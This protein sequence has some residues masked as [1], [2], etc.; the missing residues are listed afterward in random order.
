MLDNL[1]ETCRPPSCWPISHAQEHAYPHR[2]PA[3]QCRSATSPS[4]FSFDSRWPLLAGFGALMAVT[5]AGFPAPRSFTAR[6]NVSDFRTAR[7]RADIE[8]LHQ[9]VAVLNLGNLCGARMGWAA[10]AAG[11]TH[12]LN[13]PAEIGNKEKLPSPRATALLPG[14]CDACKQGFFKNITPP[15]SVFTSFPAR[16]C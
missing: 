3:P 15:C 5:R 14:L 2:P 7:T 16:L 4:G 8:G 11:S 6:G 13:A 9:E 12:T 10:I 1:S